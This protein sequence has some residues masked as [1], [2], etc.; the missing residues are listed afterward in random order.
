MARGESYEEFVEKF[1]IKKTTDDCYTPK[2]VYEI[3]LDWVKK[4]Y[5]ISDDVEIVRPFY[6]GGDYKNFNYPKN[7]VVIDNPPFSISFEIKKFFCDRKINFFL[8]QPHLTL[9]TS[10]TE[11]MKDI[12]YIVAGV[13]LIYENGANVKTSF[14][15]NLDK[16]YKIRLVP[17]FKSAIETKTNKRTVYE[18]PK[19]VITSALLTKYINKG[20]CMDF[21]KDEC[22]KIAN[23]D[24]L[25]EKRLKLFGSGFLISSKKADELNKKNVSKD[26]DYVVELSDKEREIIKRL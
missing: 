4:E 16:K 2:N 11:S 7:C 22:F 24:F 9:F 25:K 26:V 19:N 21:K 15:T 17:Y 1:K 13:K 23:L 6:P 20:V 8:F 14:C 12:C 18:Y 5:K 10:E 3:V